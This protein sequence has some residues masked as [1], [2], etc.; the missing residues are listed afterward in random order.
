MTDWN[1]LVMDLLLYVK[2][3]LK[4]KFSSD[5]GPWDKIRTNGG[6]IWGSLI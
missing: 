5:M 6:L 2:R 4:A 3:H 1:I